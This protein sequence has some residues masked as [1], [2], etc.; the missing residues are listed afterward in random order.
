MDL[1]VVFKL[2]P[3][4]ALTVLHSFSA[5]SDGAVPE[6]PLLLAAK[7]N[8]FGTTTS[9]GSGY[10]TVFKIAP[11]G[12]ETVL[13]RFAAGNDGTNPT[14]A[15]VE[16][17]NGNLYGTTDF[18]GRTGCNGTGCGVIFRVTQKGSEKV[19]QALGDGSNGYYPFAGLISDG[20]G[21]LFGTTPSA[22]ALAQVRYSSF[23][24][25]A[26]R[27]DARSLPREMTALLRFGVHGRT[28]ATVAVTEPEL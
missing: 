4:G 21:H 24:N 14:A 28:A 9:G 26:C 25:S 2:A 1:G 13:Y 10:G 3:D 27:D 6:A 23:D 15:L 8:L 22:E 20:L 11:D 19:L 12:T 16:D 7:G 5:G 17:T 18:G